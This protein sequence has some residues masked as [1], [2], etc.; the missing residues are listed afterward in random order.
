M[1]EPDTRPPPRRRWALFLY[2]SIFI[3]ITC[4]TTVTLSIRGYIPFDPFTALVAGLF[5]GF[6]FVM[7]Q[8]TYMRF[9]VNSSR[10]MHQKEPDL[11]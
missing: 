6:A 10:R 8:L 3:I 5:A 7:F 9:V 1:S 2:V 11:V 4:A